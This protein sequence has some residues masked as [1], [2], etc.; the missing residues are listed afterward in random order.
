MKALWALAAAVVSVAAAGAVFADD[1][2]RVYV[3][4]PNDQNAY[5]PQIQPKPLPPDNYIPGGV[6]PPPVQPGQVAP[7]QPMQGAFV[8]VQPAGGT[9]IRNED[10][11]VQA[12]V[13]HRSPR[14]MVFVNRTINGDPLP[15]DG[16]DE[17]LRVEEHQTATGAV[18]V[19]S[20]KTDTS[21]SQ[22]SSAGYGGSSVSNSNANSVNSNSFSSNGPADYSHTTTVKKAADKYDNIGA[23]AA[24]YA[25]IE[26]S[27]VK[28]FDDSGKVTIEDADAARAKLDREKVLRIENGDANAVRLLNTELQ[29]DILIRVTATPTSHAT[30]GTAVRLLAKAVSTADGRM[31]GTAFVDMPL[32]MS[33][34]NINLYTGYLSSELMGD[35]AKKWSNGSD[36]V[37]VRIY[38]AASVDDS[39]KIR[40][41]LQKTHGVNSVVSRGATGGGTTSYADFSVQYAGAPEDLY[42]DLKDAIGQSQGIK[43][44][45]LQNTTI[46]LE[47]TG[48]LNLVTTTRKTESI[49]T[50]TTTEERHVEPINPAL[51][52]TPNTGTADVPQTTGG[53]TQ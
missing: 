34:T 26:D 10:A 51:P 17:L 16:L 3:P 45:D 27:I 8:P 7:G 31:L 24:D 46:D 15:K 6:T 52:T 47:V 44:V 50:T 32:P 19:Q 43:A 41:W 2:Q 29:Q 23:S 33:K 9:S 13:A 39:L 40:T 20:N 53:A 5:Q 11:F 4:P 25:M 30:I 42:A 12:Y 21:N 1:V 36:V 28:Y 14:I 48:Q 38:K 35:M 18:N 49:T 22:S 37:D